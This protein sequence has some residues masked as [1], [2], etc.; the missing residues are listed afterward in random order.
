[1]KPKAFDRKA[2]AAEPESVVPL[3]DVG[4]PFARSGVKIV[5]AIVGESGNSGPG[6]RWDDCRDRR[7]N[8]CNREQP[9]P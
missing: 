4:E 2:S 7:Y 8:R 3:S 6:K 9:R 1:V 5:G